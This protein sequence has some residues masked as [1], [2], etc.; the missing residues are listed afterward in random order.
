MLCS[1]GVDLYFNTDIINISH[2]LQFIGKLWTHV[3]RLLIPLIKISIEQVLL[4]DH[5]IIV[6]RILHSPKQWTSSHDIDFI[7]LSNEKTFWQQHNFYHNFS[8]RHMNAVSIA[9]QINTLVQATNNA[10]PMWRHFYS[11][12]VVTFDCTNYTTCVLYNRAT[13]SRDSSRTL[14]V[15]S[16]IVGCPQQNE[17]NKKLLLNTS[18]YV[19]S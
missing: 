14:N 11:S 18:E 2:I 15:T 8:S 9:S 7:S 6:I 4:P 3:L 16:R 5:N 10:N 12:P 1:P 13:V 19:K 17:P